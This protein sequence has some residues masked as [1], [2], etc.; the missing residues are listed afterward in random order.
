MSMHPNTRRMFD[1]GYE[2]LTLAL[3]IPIEEFDGW[4]HFFGAA[5]GG[6]YQAKALGDLDTLL[7]QFKT[8]EFWEMHM[9]NRRRDLGRK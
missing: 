6:L 4:R 7:H 3:T 8:A 1:L 2:I 5:W 9:K